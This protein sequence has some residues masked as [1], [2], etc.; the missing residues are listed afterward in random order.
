MDSAPFIVLGC[1]Y[2][3]SKQTSI[4]CYHMISS[5]ALEVGVELCKDCGKIGISEFDVGL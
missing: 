5:G 1:S 4:T 2:E 3:H